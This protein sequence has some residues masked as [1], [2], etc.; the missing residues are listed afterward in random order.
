M[1]PVLGENRRI[2]TS[3]CGYL[4]GERSYGQVLPQLAGLL[5]GEAQRLGQAVA[6][7]GSQ[8]ECDGMLKVD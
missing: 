7:A 6:P 8:D 1:L 5:M 4:I 2:L 3:P